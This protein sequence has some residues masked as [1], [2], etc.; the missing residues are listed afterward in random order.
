ML[1]QV[2]P[3]SADETKGS[4]IRWPSGRPQRR[5]RAACG[6]PRTRHRDHRES[7]CG[8]RHPLPGEAR[9]QV[10]G[11]GV[12]GDQD[13]GLH[14]VRQLPHDSEELTVG[15]GIQAIVDPRLRRDSASA[16][17]EVPGATSATGRGHDREVNAVDARGQ[18]PPSDRRL[19]SSALG[20]GP[21]RG[22]PRFPTSPT[23]HAA[24]ES[25]CARH[26]PPRS[27]QWP[28]DKPRWCRPDDTAGRSQPRC[29]VNL[30]KSPSSQSG[31]SPP[32]STASTL[33]KRSRHAALP[34][35]RT[36]VNEGRCTDRLDGL[37]QVTCSITSPR[38]S[39]WATGSTTEANVDASVA[40]RWTPT[41]RC[42]TSGTRRRTRWPGTRSCR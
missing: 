2:G 32:R 23:S 7:R 12:V 10:L 25:G 1:A 34:C 16:R 19:S 24:A 17:N 11:P 35:A 36:A 28:H 18:P 13:H 30:E 37:Q 9:N 27:T 3:R 6:R 22:Q 15:R 8:H 29:R 14:V 42:T 5:W 20:Q 40:P 33:T 31:A 4:L 41:G 26:P 39:R 38:R 21:R